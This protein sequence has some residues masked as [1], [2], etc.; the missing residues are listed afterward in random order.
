MRHVL[1]L[2]VL[3]IVAS[4]LLAAE[5]P[6]ARPNILFVFS[7]DHALEAISAYGGRFKDIAPTPNLDRI[8]REGALFEN[9]FCA[10]SICGPSRACILTGK[11]SHVNGFRQNSDRFDGDQWCFHKDLGQVGYSTS[12]IGKWH[13]GGTPKGFDHWEI[14]PGQGSY[15]NPDFLTMDGK[16]H[17]ENGYATDLVT[18]KAIDWLNRRDKSKPFLLMCQHKAPHRTFAPALRHLSALDGVKFPEPASLFDDY[19]TRS[20]VLGQNQMSIANHL[21]WTYDLKVRPTEHKGIVLPGPDKGFAIEYQRMN[22]D[23]KQAW[24]QHFA[25]LNQ[26]F[27]ADFQDGKYS[28]RTDLTKWLYQRYMQNYLS[29]IKAVDES[30]GRLLA[31]LDD[32][33]LTEN[34]IV[35]YSSDQGF[36][37][38]EHGWYDKRW[39]FEESFKMPLMVRWPGVVKPGIQ[40]QALVQNIDYAPT[41]LDVAGVAI[42]DEVQG[43]SL[44]PILSDAGHRPSD[45]RESLYYHYYESG[46]EHNVPEHDGVRTDRYKLIHFIE[47]DEWNLF[48][49]EAD[50]HEM[51]NLYDHPESKDLRE[52]LTRELQRLR[53]Q[54]QVSSEP[55]LEPVQ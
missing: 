10:N 28:D 13:L 32:N 33:G 45:W 24:D 49:L 22:D 15:Y 20:S 4:Q 25:P 42:P 7:D 1:I 29:T 35:I 50:P 17:R 5:K 37:L 46:G 27:I 44:L 18:D 52:Q 47:T 34:T 48:D 3:S 39:M 21:R 6:D 30:V 9:S 40:P 23:Q 12:I 26:K 43:R 11:H 54:Y 8:A 16:R 38:G 36:Y 19:S 51:N 55:V 31:Y 2:V 41:F 53:D 14:F